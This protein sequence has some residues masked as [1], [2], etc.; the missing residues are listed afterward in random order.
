M[1]MNLDAYLLRIGHA[2]G[3]APTLHTLREILAR[4]TE[5][6]AFENLD[7]LL[8]WPVRLDPEWLQRKMVQG[9]RGGY[10]YEQNLLLSHALQSLG[11]SVAGLAARVLWNAAVAGAVPPRTHMLLR[12]D[13]D[14]QPLLVDAGFGVMT[15]TAPLRLEAD[16]EQ[17]TPHEPFRLLADRDEF[18]MQAKIRGEWRSLYRFGLQEQLLPDYE[19][20]NWYVSTHPKSRFANELM[21]A[22]PAS[23]RRYTLL[24][25]EFAVHYLNGS[26]E[27]RKLTS[28]AEIRT[29]LE[30]E[31]QLKL[32]DTPELDSALWRLIA[33]AG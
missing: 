3:R 33:P 10:C 27:Q 25:N 30:G 32:P 16:E 8:K 12:V 28:A 23:G 2:G 19:L 9:G 17:A 7:P 5:A 21:V 14:G 18:V 31:F 15:P 4:H 24:N 13:L 22:R 1:A 26:T 29:L 11:Y 20:A 6:I